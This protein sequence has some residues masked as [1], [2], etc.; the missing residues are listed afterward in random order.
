MSRSKRTFRS[1]RVR[2]RLAQARVVA[3][4]VSDNSYSGATTVLL[5]AMAMGKPVVVSRTDAIAEGYELEDGV[6]CRLVKPGDAQGLE[7]AVLETL[8]GADAAHSRHP[9]PRNGR[10]ES[11]V[12]ALHERALADLLR[13]GPDLDDEAGSRVRAKLVGHLQS[14]AVRPGFARRSGDHTGSRVQLQSG[15]KQTGTSAE[16]DPRARSDA[17]GRPEDDAVLLADLRGGEWLPR[18]QQPRRHV[19]LNVSVLVTPSESV[20]TSWNRWTARMPSVCR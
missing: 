9:R 20:T 13:L 3:L 11:H 6:N 8:A 4:P 5:Q 15:R 14:Q 16:H 2:D 17:A 19:E 12:G 7:R 10:A 1:N 18:D